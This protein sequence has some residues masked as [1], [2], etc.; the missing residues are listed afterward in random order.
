MS[1]AGAAGDAAAATGALAGSGASAASSDAQVKL[2]SVR[3]NWDWL[4][5]QNAWERNWVSIGG[6][7]LLLIFQV[8]WRVLFLTC[9]I[10]SE[11]AKVIIAKDWSFNDSNSSHSWYFYFSI[12]ASAFSDHVS[13][14]S[15]YSIY[16][17]YDP[18]SMTSAA[19]G[20]SRHLY[21]EHMRQVRW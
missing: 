17:S 5:R 11:N 7:R 16:S 15:P 1:E 12:S 21:E 10:Q 18:F 6:A 8:P 2:R 4:L 13:F 20:T 3:A 9:D 14:A 19:Y